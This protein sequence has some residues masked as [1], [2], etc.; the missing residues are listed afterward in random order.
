MHRG[1]W[2]RKKRDLFIKVCKETATPGSTEESRGSDH[3]PLSKSRR[4]LETCLRQSLG[5]TLT[6]KERQDASLVEGRKRMLE[7]KVGGDIGLHFHRL[8]AKRDMPLLWRAARAHQRQPPP[9][10]SR[11][12]LHPTKPQ[13]SEGSTS[14]SGPGSLSG[15]FGK[16]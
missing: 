12:P 10:S 9:P 1:L 13:N 5:P 2:R 6:L 14:S 7:Q 11:E 8:R 15:W 3:R 4:C 16:S